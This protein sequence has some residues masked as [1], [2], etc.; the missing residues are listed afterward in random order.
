MYAD[1]FLAAEHAA[2]TQREQAAAASRSRLARLATYAERC[3]RASTTFV[4]RLNAA[5]SPPSEP[6][7]S[8]CS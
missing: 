8:D 3:A 5:L 6:R 1:A 4:Q 7:P 2:H